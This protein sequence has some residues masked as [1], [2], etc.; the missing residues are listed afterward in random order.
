M[1]NEAL[2]DEIQDRILELKSEQV[3]L[4]PFIAS[5]QSRW[6]ALAKAIDELNWVLKRV[7]SAEES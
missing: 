4:K 7:E 3:L 2:A 1:R 6:E 5:D